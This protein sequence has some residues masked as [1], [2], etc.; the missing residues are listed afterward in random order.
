MWEERPFYV[1]M[2]HAFILNMFFLS[3]MSHPAK[4]SFNFC[5][6]PHVDL[7]IDYV[8]GPPNNVGSNILVSSWSQK[9]RSLLRIS[10]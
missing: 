4:L 10:L 6:K 7:Q 8:F 1:S 5:D 3:K 9:E 2:F